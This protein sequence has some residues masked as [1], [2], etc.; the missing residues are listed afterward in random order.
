MSGIIDENI[1]SLVFDNSRF[2]SGVTDTLK[3]VSGL[4]KNL[5]FAGAHAFDSLD[6]SVRKVDI[7]PL[8]KAFDTLTDKSTWATTTALNCMIRLENR[9]IEFAKRVTDALTVKPIMEGFNTYEA[10]LEATQTIMS[11]TGESL[12]KVNKKIDELNKYS[13]ETIYS[14]KDMTM[15]IGKFTNAGVSL[16][17]SVQA[18]M[19]VSNAAAIAGANANEASRAMYN[20]AQSLAMGY[21]QYIDWKSIE[22]ANMATKDFKKHIADVGVA[23][24]TVEKINEDLYKVAGKEYNLQGLFKDALKDQWLTSDTLINVLKEYADSE[25]EIGKK[26]FAA[27]KDLKTLTQMMD[28]LREGA[29]SKWAQTFQLLIGDLTEAKVMLKQVAAPIEEIIDMSAEFRNG[30]IS[31]GFTDGFSELK[32]TIEAAGLSNDDFEKKLINHARVEGVHIDTLIKKYDNLAGVIT[33]G[34]IPK[35]IISDVLTDMAKS[36]EDTAET[37]DEEIKRIDSFNAAV[38]RVKKQHFETTY[39]ER[40]AMMEEL[41]KAGFNYANTSSL[42]TRVL[43][44]EKLTMEEL[45]TAELRSLAFTEEQVKKLSKYQL[46]LGD[47]TKRVSQLT[48]Q[49]SRANVRFLWLDTLRSA[50]ETLKNVVGSAET[51][52]NQVFGKKLPDG[53]QTAVERIHSF[54]EGLQLTQDKIDKLTHGFRGIF[55]VLDAVGYAMKS[56]INFVIKVLNTMLPSLNLNLFDMTDKVGN[57]GERFNHFVKSVHP[58]EAAFKKM[59]PY[60][61]RVPKLLAKAVEKGKE[62]AKLGKDAVDKFI[63]GMEGNKSTLIGKI[64][65]L[66]KQVIESIKQIFKTGFSLFG[67][68]SIGGD[69]TKGV[70]D[71]FKIA[72]KSIEKTIDMIASFFS[73]T[74][75]NGK[76]LA[77]A[78]KDIDYGLILRL[79]IFGTALKHLIKA[80]FDVKSTFKSTTTFLGSMMNFLKSSQ[81][82]FTSIK[83]GVDKVTNTMSIKNLAQ[84]ISELGETVKNIALSVLLISISCRLLSKCSWSDISKAQT[85]LGTVSGL[86]VGMIIAL[87]AIDKNMGNKFSFK[88]INMILSSGV[89]GV[90]GAVIMELTVCMG[91]IAL[92]LHKNPGAMMAA[93]GIVSGLIIELGGL[94]VAIAAVSKIANPLAIAAGAA[95]I[96]ALG[97]AILP[98]VAAVI[99]LG[100]MKTNELIR[101]GLAT[102]I[103]IGVLVGIAI[104]CVALA[105]QLTVAGPAIATVS[106]LVG[107]LG[108]AVLEIALACKMMADVK[109]DTIIKVGL[110]ITYIAGIAT[111]MAILTKTAGF[112]AI[113]AGMLIIGFSASL[114]LIALGIEKLGSLSEDAIA[115]GLSVMVVLGGIFTVMAL[116]SRKSTSSIKF[117]KQG[118]NTAYQKDSAGGMLGMYVGFAVA[119]YVLALAIGKLAAYSPEQLAVGLG[120]II[121]LSGVFDVMLICSQGMAKAGK[122]GAAALLALVGAVALLALVAAKIGEV[123]GESLAKGVI[124]ISILSLVVESLIKTSRRLAY[125]KGIAPALLTMAV[126]LTSIGLCITIVSKY[127][128]E[129]LLGA[130]VAIAALMEMVALVS[131]QL[132]KNVIHK[133]TLKSMAMLT[134]LVVAAGAAIAI[135]CAFSKNGKEAIGAA[136]ALSLVMLSLAGTSVI[137]TKFGT[138]T[139]SFAKS[140][141]VIG[142]LSAM[143]IALGYAFSLLV[144]LDCDQM[145]TAAES[146][147]K[148]MTG[149]TVLAVACAAI[150]AIGPGAFIGVG[151]IAALMVAIAGIGILA[152]WAVMEFIIKHED[153]INKLGKI[154]ENFGKKLAPLGNS[155]KNLNKDSLDG[156]VSLMETFAKMSKMKFGDDDVKGVSTLSEFSKFLPELARSMVQFSNILT[157]GKFD[158][159]QVK[160]AAACGEMVA[161][162]WNTLPKEG[163]RIQDLLGKTKDLADFTKNLAPLGEG[164][165]DFAIA[166]GNEDLDYE[167]ANKAAAI[168]ETISKLQNN[169]PSYDGTLQE[170]FGS[171]QSLLDFGTSLWQ[172]GRACRF[173]AEG[174]RGYDEVAPDYDLAKKAGDMAEVLSKLQNNLPSYDGRLQEWFGTKQD[175]VTFGNSLWQFGRGCRFFAEGIRGYGETPP[176]YDLADTAANVAKTLATLESRLPSYGGKLTKWF[177]EK[178]DLQT[179]GQQLGSFGEQLGGVL[180][181]WANTKATSLQVERAEQLAQFAADLE[182]NLPT[183]DGKLTGWF[184]KKQDLSHFAENLGPFGKG[185]SAFMEN[186]QGIEVVDAILVTRAIQGLNNLAEESNINNIDALAAINKENVISCKENVVELAKMLI[187]FE[188]NMKGINGYN[189]SS[190]TN[191]LKNLIDMATTIDGANYGGLSDFKTGMENIAYDSI[192]NFCN[193]FDG[194]DEKVSGAFDIF[195][196]TVESAMYE[197][198][199][200]WKSVGNHLIVQFGSGVLEKMS[201]AREQGEKVARET[202]DGYNS[203]HMDFFA[204]GQNFVSGLVDGMKADMWRAAWIADELGKNTIAALKKAL[205]EHSP[206]KITYGMGEYFVDGLTNGIESKYDQAIRSSDGLGNG[207]IDAMQKAMNDVNDMMNSDTDAFTIRPVVDLSNVEDASN[208]IAKL[209]DNSPSIKSAVSNISSMYG[210]SSSKY[211]SLIDTLNGIERGGNTTNNTYNVNGVTY[212]DGTNVANAVESLIS[213]AN[214]RRRV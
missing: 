107:S 39:A 116:F 85:I 125:A 206:S 131:K 35:Q 72:K 133:N 103:I 2:Q 187:A 96:V 191:S 151:V 11:A 104:G 129:N 176:D 1:V 54:V 156:F 99:I 146:L 117:L 75:A 91:I 196:S 212:D 157:D 120:V 7:S 28:T 92:L 34:G 8:S 94:A 141:I 86:L 173:F 189:L 15:N 121:V 61:E 152:A 190:V 6:K 188:E 69:I 182:T 118:K 199:D 45:S 178:Q 170:W 38:E 166:V 208:N 9:V 124:A 51:A 155:F 162:I 36:A 142:L 27:A 49:M 201:D 200:S 74:S 194:A 203:Y 147:L 172:F 164:I 24:G 198:L 154:L 108:T 5:D 88:G 163:G 73:S 143:M 93:F 3:I 22:N 168:A 57:L 98:T 138:G 76:R 42:V 214:I 160:A 136:A 56:G 111:A 23:M 26:A 67:K 180:N 17:D 211:A 102:G 19:G 29:A 60:L 77:T 128:G 101:G 14:F 209:F 195:N 171:K 110:L 79:G 50:M 175:L 87:S 41:T 144:G 148:V 167:L 150:G 58:L 64:G 183:T 71:A 159:D 32:D 158:S 63:E 204:A 106:L 207:L 115:K 59:E 119:C 95:V 113:G 65:N 179:F 105:S 184:S 186:I 112:G 213:A 177:G 123:D 122:G 43:N 197:N 149:L 174:V 161:K 18:I 48:D 165:R 37:F 10:R 55:L 137:I 33:A 135:V 78:A 181:C 47:T 132:S 25:T 68:D 130:T 90:L 109:F 127:S 81:N 185:I 52:F 83:L 4:T 62:F 66:F 40:T 192:D 100:K 89:L 82:L 97:T 46:S 134:A 153:D 44:G 13:D 202:R 31:Q 193:V 20:L 21:V 84:S 126:L 70:T 140:I 205:D 139:G 169:L 145:L 114:L 16:D 80:F 53:F 12:D 30:L 210:T